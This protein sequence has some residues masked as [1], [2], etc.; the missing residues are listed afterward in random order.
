[1][2]QI[3]APWRFAFPVDGLIS[4]FKHHQDWPSG[5]LLTQYLAQH[6][7]DAYR[8]ELP[9]P[10]ALIPIP[11]SARRLRQ[12]GFDQTRWLADWLGKPLKKTVGADWVR[13]VRDTPSQQ[14][15]NAH[16]RRHNMQQ[17]FAVS[18]HAPSL[19]GRHLAIVDDVVTTGATAEA[20]ASVLLAA[21]ARRV[22]LY[23]LA[24]TPRP[25]APR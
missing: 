24:R 1:M 15:L 17:A 16:E 13:R 19:M 23:C 4:R 10:E 5:Y 18:P 12:R 7:S 14:G 3:V 9:Q 6:L 22:D 20:L 11:L 8:A 21:G 25:S 2:G